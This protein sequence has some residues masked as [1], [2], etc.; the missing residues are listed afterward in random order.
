[1]AV[2]ELILSPIVWVMGALLNF[3]ISVL[4]STGLSIL[5]LSFTFSLFLLPLQRIASRT[6][7]RIGVKIATVDAEVNALKGSLKGEKLFLATEK[8]YQKHGYHPIQSV[9][10]GAGFIVMLPVLVSAILL[11]TGGGVLAG[12]AFLFIHDLSK[13]D[14]VIGPLNVLPIIMFAVTLVDAKLRFKN[15]QKSQVR[16]LFISVVLLAI[17][18]N[19]AAGL[20]LY[21]T[22]S[23]LMSL[24]INQIRKA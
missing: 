24:V 16:F 7:Q 18:Y 17:V 9:A 10:M 19:L 6:E 20:V 22:G 11:F 15:D 5:I 12:Q 3:Y 23:N 2:F 1:M 13:P 14:G 4:S 21:W 8:I